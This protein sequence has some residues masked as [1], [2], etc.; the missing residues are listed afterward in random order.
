M[1]Y[2]GTALVG[3]AGP[4]LLRLPGGAQITPM[5]GGVAGAA[6]VVPLYLDGREVARAVARV[7]SDQLARA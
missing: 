7:T 5:P 1:P 3:E 6:I 2:S 4:E